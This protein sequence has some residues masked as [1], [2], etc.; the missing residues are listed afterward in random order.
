[1]TLVSFPLNCCF[2]AWM[3]EGRWKEKPNRRI[4][5]HLRRPQRRAYEL[6]QKDGAPLTSAGLSTHVDK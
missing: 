1:M 4:V 6:G 3:L 2:A 5:S